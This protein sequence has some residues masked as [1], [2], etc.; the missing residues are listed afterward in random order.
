MFRVM[1]VWWQSD[2]VNTKERVLPD[3]DTHAYKYNR[4]QNK[5]RRMGD[6]DLDLK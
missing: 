5:Y 1:I 2:L 6:V 3:W 4:Q